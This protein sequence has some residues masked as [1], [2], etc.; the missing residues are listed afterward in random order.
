MVLI[1]LQYLKEIYQFQTFFFSLYQVKLISPIKLSLNGGN[2]KM[3]AQP[4]QANLNIL[5]KY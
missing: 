4:Q 1:E 5:I 2:R 3:Q